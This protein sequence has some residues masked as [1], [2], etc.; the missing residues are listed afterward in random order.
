MAFPGGRWSEG[1]SDLLTTAARETR[2]EVGVDLSAARLLGR[3]DDSAPRS[4]SLPP[5][6]VTP[7]VFALERHA[8]LEPNHEVAGAFWTPIER[9][10][11]PGILRPYPFEVR[12]ARIDFPGY[13]LDQG[14][15]WGMTERILTPLLRIM[16]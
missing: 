6:I 1:D 11:D 14:V 16:A 2:E 7:Y 15:V 9:L 3:L 13:H 5:I 8:P 4:Q 10:V 12:G